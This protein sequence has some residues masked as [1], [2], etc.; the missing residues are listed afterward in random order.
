MGKGKPADED[1]DDEEPEYEYLKCG[2]NPLDSAICAFARLNLENYVDKKPSMFDRFESV[3]AI[4]F[5]FIVMF[6][7]LFI[8]WVFFVYWV[9]DFEDPWED[10]NFKPMKAVITNATLFRRSL[11][12]DNSPMATTI[13]QLCT[14]N[15]ATPLFHFMVL[16]MWFGVGLNMVG[17]SVWRLYVVGQLS[18]EL[19]TPEQNDDDEIS[20]KVIC[21][22]PPPGERDSTINISSMS[23]PYKIIIFALI[24]LPNFLLSLF[25][26]WTG[27][28][29]LSVVCQVNVLVKS[30]LKMN[31][32]AGIDKM[33]APSFISFNWEDYVKNNKYKVAVPKGMPD[34]FNTWKTTVIKAAAGVL[35]SY[36]YMWI[37]F[38]NVE[39]FRQLCLTY[40][41]TFPSE[42]SQHADW[43]YPEL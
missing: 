33:I 17:E 20:S 5:Y 19:N 27:A 25:I 24:L 39:A 14:E 22:D 31:F 23:R 29:Y 35:G 13:L 21:V 41:D 43:W 32:V 3:V 28:K 6:F 12:Y 30:S 4:F 11:L 15:R 16:W 26:A 36:M 8:I 2:V 42:N 18:T 1:K 9:E 40:Y 10:A 7:K 34:M 38:P 37:F